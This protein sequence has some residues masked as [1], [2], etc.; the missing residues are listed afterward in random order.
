[1]IKNDQKWSKMIKIV[2]FSSE[3]LIKFNSRL[4][5]LREFISFPY[6]NIFMLSQTKSQIKVNKNNFLINSGIF[7]FN[8]VVRALINQTELRSSSIYSVFKFFV[9]Q[10]LC[11]FNY[12]WDSVTFGIGNWQTVTSDRASLKRLLSKYLIKY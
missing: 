11:E 6:N 7:I 9:L 4:F 3:S 10:F 1:M 5:L 2:F 8:S 12:G